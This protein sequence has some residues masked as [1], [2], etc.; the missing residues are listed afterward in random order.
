MDIK[1]HSVFFFSIVKKLDNVGLDPKYDLDNEHVIIEE[2]NFLFGGS[3]KFKI[4]SPILKVEDRATMEDIYWRVFGTSIVTNNEIL[5]W[6]V[7]GFITHSRGHPINWAKVVE[8]I[9]K[10]KAHLDGMKVG[11]LIVVKK[12]HT[13][14]S[15]ELCGGSLNP[16]SDQ[17]MPL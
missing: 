6:I 14:D 4:N 16:S 10:K 1:K 15:L 9:T 5:A 7:R 13:M 2:C 12:E 17:H 8:S 3:K 11:Q